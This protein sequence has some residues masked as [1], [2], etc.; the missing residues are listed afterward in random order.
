MLKNLA[1]NF[2]LVLNLM[3]LLQLL[4]A[5]SYPP[6]IKENIFPADV[7]RRAEQILSTINKST[8]C[9]SDSAG[10]AIVKKHISEFISTRDGYPSNSDHI[11][12]TNGAST[13]VKV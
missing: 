6:L 7:N 4:A 10:L 11:I 2:M 12:I 3:L 1:F 5:C 8:G 9:Y 13:A